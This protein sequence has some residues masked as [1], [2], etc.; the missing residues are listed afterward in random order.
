MADRDPGGANDPDKTKAQVG[1]PLDFSAR[2]IDQEPACCTPPA[3]A[4][5]KPGVPTSRGG[6]GRD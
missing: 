2:T 5:C 3:Q 6:H 1:Y 4:E